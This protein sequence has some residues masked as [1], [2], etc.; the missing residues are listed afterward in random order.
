MS[1]DDAHAAAQAS[2][3]SNVEVPPTWSGI[4]LWALTKWGMGIVGF[5]LVVPLYMDL[6]ASNERFASIT[7]NNVKAIT[8]FSK[9]VE[10]MTRQSQRN[11]DSMTRQAQRFEDSIRRLEQ[12]QRSP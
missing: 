1:L 7:E 6:K 11:D 2:T 4:A 12:I 5:L 10:E 8:I 9:N 3:P